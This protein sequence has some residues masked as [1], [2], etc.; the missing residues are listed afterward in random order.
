MSGIEASFFDVTSLDRMAAGDTALHRLDPRAKVIVT[1]AFLLAVVSVGK[2]EV[3]RL[4]PFFIFPVA[5]AVAGNLPLRDLCGKVCL[6]IP[7]AA[8]VGGF[9][10]LLDRQVLFEFGS[11]GVAGGWV[12]LASIVVRAVL[13]AAA[14]LLLVALTGFPALCAALERLGVPQPFTVQLLFLYR[15]LFVLG[16]EGARAVRARELRSCGRRGR[17]FRGWGSLLGHLLLRS[18]LRAERVHSAML[19]RGFTGGFPAR[20]TPGFGRGEW[21]FVLG[22]SAGFLLFRLYDVTGLLRGVAG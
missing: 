19:A 16:G 8:A 17:G 6:V 15:Y 3:L 22:C 1:V 11:F 9:N 7:F 18:S 5:M 20:R 21:I 4:L 14:A 2:Y 10:P 12:S 13:T